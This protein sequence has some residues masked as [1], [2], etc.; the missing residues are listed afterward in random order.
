MS[1]HTIYLSEEQDRF[2]KSMKEKFGSISEVI[3]VGLKRFQQEELREYY[4]QKGQQ[5]SE[6]RKAQKKVLERS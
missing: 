4:Q 5:Y 3:R 2:V 1:R 6:L